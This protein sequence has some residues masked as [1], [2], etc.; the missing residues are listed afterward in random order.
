MAGHWKEAV[1]AFNQSIALD[2]SIEFSYFG[3][4]PLLALTGDQ[5][6]YQRL[7][8]QLIAQPRRADNPNVTL[9]TAMACLLRAPAEQDLARVAKMMD[10]PPQQTPIYSLGKGML[11]YRMGHFADAAT[12]LK[13]A[14]D[15]KRGGPLADA[16]S[17]AVL[18]M[19]QVRL[20]QPD[21][22]RASPRRRPVNLLN[23][24]LPTVES[25]DLGGGWEGWVASRALIDEARAMVP[26]AAPPHQAASLA[27]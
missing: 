6:G 12:W 1:A 9:N 13:K 3:L 8:A 4:A 15:S 11:E 20:A 17:C 27:P 5:Q 22:A 19:A 14:L 25:G 7:C 18:A 26:E 23:T 16:E 2:P 24:K 21:F 10:F